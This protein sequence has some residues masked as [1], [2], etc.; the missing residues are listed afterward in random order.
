MIFQGTIMEGRSVS[1]CK[2]RLAEVDYVGSEVRVNVEE[3]RTGKILT[4]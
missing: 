3:P 1:N 4:C 2:C